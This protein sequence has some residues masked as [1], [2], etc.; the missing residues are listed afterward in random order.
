MIEKRWVA[1]CS[2]FF[3]E[4]AMR[5]LVTGGAGFIGTCF[6]KYCLKRYPD[7]EVF[8]L[9]KLTYAGNL[10]NL[11]DLESE[12]RHHFIRGDIGDAALIGSIAREGV[13]AI[14]NFAAETHVDRSIEEPNA[15]VVTNVLGTQT[16]LEAQRKFMI[17]RFVQISTDE[18]Y[19]S[20]GPED[21]F[22]ED[23]PLSPSSPYSASKAAA[24]LLVMAYHKTYK[25]PVFIT[26]C[27]N[28]Y[29]PYQFPEKFIPLLIS[30]ALNNVALPIYGDGLNIRDWLY[31]EDHC[32]AID[33]VLHHGKAGEVYNIGGNNERRNL[34]VVKTILKSLDKPESLIS[35]V[36]DRPGHDRRYAIDATKIRREL[37][38]E[39]LTTFDVGIQSTIQ[40]YQTHQSWSNAIQ[41]GDY[42]HYYEKMYGQ[43]ATT[44][45]KHGN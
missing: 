31:V 42:R 44:L 16:L 7:V 21:Y 32:R 37:G 9:D 36:K 23:S 5:L 34:E 28:N 11:A 39:P 2:F 30:N 27:S 38:W 45:E 29:G 1:G 25:Q 3:L 43:R 35:F 17:G 15:F 8:N 40:W 22:R 13:N 10:E 18:V 6:V 4:R 12:P 41:Q 14:V 19:G 20:L 24:D 26:R 33:L